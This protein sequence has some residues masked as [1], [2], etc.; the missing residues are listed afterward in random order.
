MVPLLH[1]L[2]TVLRKRKHETSQVPP[3]A[4]ERQNLE[5]H[6][7]EHSKLVEP[8]SLTEL[9]GTESRRWKGTKVIVTPFASDTILE[10]AGEKNLRTDVLNTAYGPMQHALEHLGFALPAWADK[11]QKQTDRALLECFITSLPHR[12]PDL[13]T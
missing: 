1:H 9:L 5:F 8:C 4:V 12:F 3:T 10:M 6:F 11:A 2:G 13:L 7:G